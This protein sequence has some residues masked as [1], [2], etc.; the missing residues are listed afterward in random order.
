MVH[1]NVITVK[2]T[3][4]VRRLCTTNFQ[5]PTSYIFVQIDKDFSE[6]LSGYGCVGHI[7]EVKGLVQS[8]LEKVALE[9][10]TRA[11]GMLMPTFGLGFFVPST[12]DPCFLD[13][14]EGLTKSATRT[15]SESDPVRFDPLAV[16]SV[17]GLGGAS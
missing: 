7:P 11:P 2:H 5:L 10:E 6:K 17:E 4:C 3:S 12:P 15:V 8:L 1:I 14:L 16:R 13:D 9:A